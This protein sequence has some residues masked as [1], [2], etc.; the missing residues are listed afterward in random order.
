MV[1]YDKIRLSKPQ[2][3]E[4]TKIKL[5]STVR[6]WPRLGSRPRPDWWLQIKRT[7]T[8]RIKQTLSSWIWPML[9]VCKIVLYVSGNWWGKHY[10]GVDSVSGTLGHVPCGAAGGGS[11]DIW[12]WGVMV[13]M[14]TLTL[15]SSSGCHYLWWV[16][17]P[18]MYG[19]TPG[20]S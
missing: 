4:I 17:T 13:V 20:R 7:K 8:K 19:H 14:V 2:S 10:H 6:V 15:L 3:R 11:S 9:R 5:T 18:P 1:Q 16:P 12:G